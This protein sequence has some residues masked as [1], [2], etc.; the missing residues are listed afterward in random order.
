MQQS[1]RSLVTTPN[2][3]LFILPKN[4]NTP[5]KGQILG[6]FCD[7]GDVVLSFEI[8]FQADETTD[9]LSSF[10]KFKDVLQNNDEL[11]SYI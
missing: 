5:L 1:L 7:S 4:Q 3:S 2:L 9:S 10:S 11:E 6:E 8:V